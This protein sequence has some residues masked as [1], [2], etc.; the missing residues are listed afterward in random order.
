M[1]SECNAS[2]SAMNAEVVIIHA[3]IATVPFDKR[4]FMLVILGDSP[5]KGIR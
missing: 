4:S 3:V 2:F 5:A 1:D